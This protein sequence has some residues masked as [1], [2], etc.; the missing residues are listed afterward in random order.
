[1]SLQ[2]RIVDGLGRAG[3]DLVD[4]PSQAGPMKVL[5]TFLGGQPGR[6]AWVYACAVQMWVTVA[7]DRVDGEDTMTDLIHS[8]QDVPDCYPMLRSAEASY[9]DAPPGVSHSDRW[10]ELVVYCQDR[11]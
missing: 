1:M 9:P 4:L 11:E 8:L 3:Y 2:S 10:C 7:R 6:T 5:V